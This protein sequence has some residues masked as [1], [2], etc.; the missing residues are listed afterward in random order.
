[1]RFLNGQE[2]FPLTTAAQNI[3]VLF[4]KSPLCRSH[5]FEWLKTAISSTAC[6]RVTLKSTPSRGS[7][8]SHV[9][10]RLRKRPPRCTLDCGFKT[11]ESPALRGFVAERCPITGTSLYLV[12]FSNGPHRSKNLPVK[13]GFSS[14]TVSTN[15]SKKLPPQRCP[16][17]L[18]IALFNFSHKRPTFAFTSESGYTLGFAQRIAHKGSHA[19]TGVFRIGVVSLPSDCFTRFGNPAWSGGRTANFAALGSWPGA[20]PKNTESLRNSDALM[21][22]AVPRRRGPAGLRDLFRFCRNR[23]LYI[24]RSWFSACARHG[25]YH[26]HRCALCAVE[27]P[28]GRLS[29]RLFCRF[30]R[31]GSLH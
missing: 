25:W 1:M 5:F 19:E 9:H 2:A 29:K 11:L 12:I 21:R 6:G 23:N 31:L 28:D 27:I 30:L 3:H 18:F 22:V 10:P 26:Y 13:F 15:I 8:A 24:R 4:R 20:L 14:K 16:K 7:D 17:P